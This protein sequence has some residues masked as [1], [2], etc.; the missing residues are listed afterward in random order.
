MVERLLYA[1]I[2]LFDQN[3]SLSRGLKSRQKRRLRSADTDCR[4]QITDCRLQTGDKMQTEGKIQT[5]DYSSD[6]LT[7]YCVTSISEC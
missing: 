1:L 4:L 5:A 2:H 7:I 6:F 3:E